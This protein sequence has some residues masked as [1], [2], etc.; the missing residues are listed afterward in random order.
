MA[1]L[2][3]QD[4]K[5]VAHAT[6]AFFVFISLAD[7]EQSGFCFMGVHARESSL[8]ETDLLR[9]QGVLFNS[10]L[11]YVKG[12]ANVETILEDIPG[13]LWMPAFA[14][15]KRASLLLLGTADTRHDD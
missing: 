7:L 12:H 10:W 14:R 6:R 2:S 11:A 4:E 1:I 15:R 13:E 5:D 8:Q 9:L 3:V